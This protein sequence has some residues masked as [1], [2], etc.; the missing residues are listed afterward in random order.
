MGVS[1]IPF[2]L[3]QATPQATYY[4]LRVLDASGQA[5]IQK[6]YKVG[7]VCN[8]ANGICGLASPKVLAPGVYKWWIQ[9]WNDAGYGPW[10]DAGSFVTQASGNSTIYE[11]AKQNKSQVYSCSNTC[12]LNHPYPTNYC[13][14][15]WG[16]AGDLCSQQYQAELNA[17]NDSLKN[18]QAKCE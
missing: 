3:W 16:Q 6:W 7:Q 13:T 4:Y 9:T 10:S 11:N 15:S 14:S 17:R 2:F 18:C 8:D 1:T 12:T 5:I